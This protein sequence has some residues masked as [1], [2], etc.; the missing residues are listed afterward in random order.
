[1]KKFYT[2]KELQLWGQNT[3]IEEILHLQLEVK[4][5]RKLQDYVSKMDPR[6]KYEIIEIIDRIVDV[7]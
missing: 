4:D 7:D 6:A 1:M 3:L 2:L 5:F